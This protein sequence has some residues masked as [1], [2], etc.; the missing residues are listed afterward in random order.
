MANLLSKGLVLDWT[1]SS[2]NHSIMRT[3]A[4]RERY[5]TV[6]LSDDDQRGGTEACV[7]IFWIRCRHC[8]RRWRTPRQPRRH[9]RLTGC[10]SRQVS[11]SSLPGASAEFCRAHGADYFTLSFFSSGHRLCGGYGLT[12]N[13]TNHVDEGKLVDWTVSKGRTRGE[14]RVHFHVQGTAG[15]AR[16]LVHGES[17]DWTVLNDKPVDDGEG[18]LRMLPPGHAMLVRDA[19][20]EGP[21]TGDCESDG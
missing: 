7:R 8:R 2:K 19:T 3:T 20:A 10:G 21:D 16:V 15:T 12:T 18:A 6:M 13:F 1:R 5:A 14:Y 4:G 9:P 11:C 17:L